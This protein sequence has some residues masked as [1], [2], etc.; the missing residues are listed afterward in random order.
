MNSQPEK[1]TD[2]IAKDAW[3]ENTWWNSK[4][5]VGSIIAGPIVGFF[6]SLNFNN[7]DESTLPPLPMVIVIMVVATVLIYFGMVKA[8]K[9]RLGIEKWCQEHGWNF[10][11]GALH[12]LASLGFRE[13]HTKS[14]TMVNRLGITSDYMWK[15]VDDRTVLVGH[16]RIRS[17]DLVAAQVLSNNTQRDSVPLVY[18]LMEIDTPAPEVIVHPKRMHRFASTWFSKIKRS[19]F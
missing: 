17:G 3:A 13:G 14:G 16:S 8:V 7:S 4:V 2:V 5:F 9:R 11:R 12:D 15:K 6:V 18:M 1:L 19:S 10:K